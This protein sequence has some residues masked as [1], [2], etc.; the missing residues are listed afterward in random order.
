MI[1]RL[2]S[3]N[4]DTHIFAVIQFFAGTFALHPMQ[5]GTQRS[6]GAIHCERRKRQFCVCVCVC[7]HFFRFLSFPLLAVQLNCS[8]G[9]AQVRASACEQSSS[10]RS[11]LPTLVCA[12]VPCMCVC[13]R[14]RTALCANVCELALLLIIMREEETDWRRKRRKQKKHPNL[15]QPI[16]LASKRKFVRLVLFGWIAPEAIKFNSIE[17]IAD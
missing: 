15:S 7:L 11:L 5:K 16:A 4:F 2:V 3:I 8:A 14:A 10:Q 9:P 6:C 1:A 13:E 17:F 12:T